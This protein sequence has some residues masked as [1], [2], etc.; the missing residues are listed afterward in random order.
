MLMP[1]RSAPNEA[2]QEHQ[3]SNS[4][5]N[6]CERAFLH[7]IA[8]SL[9]SISVDD[10]QVLWKPIF[11]LNPYY[12]DWIDVFLSC[13]FCSNNESKLVQFAAIWK[14]MILFANKHWDEKSYDVQNLR[15]R[16]LGIYCQESFWSDAK[17]IPIIDGLS[18][19]YLEWANGSIKKHNNI[20]NYIAFCASTAGTPLRKD[21]L[22]LIAD[23]LETIYLSDNL[24][25]SSLAA[26]LCKEIWENYPNLVQDNHDLSDAFFRILSKSISL[27]SR[28][29]LDLQNIITT[30]YI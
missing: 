10:A 8:S 23:T 9:F 28:E 25:T 20:N 22:L 6:E 5:P 2:I 16:L 14:E 13:F 17:F 3:L 4:Y 18:S 21:S 29:A 30:P 24:E 12:H 26:R 11:M 7:K 19:F 1:L 27:G 15:L